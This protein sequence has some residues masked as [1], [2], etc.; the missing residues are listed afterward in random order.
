M[1]FFHFRLSPIF[2]VFFFVILTI[3]PDTPWGGQDMG[4]R[5]KKTEIQIYPVL[6]FD[7]KEWHIHPNGPKKVHIGPQVDRMYDQM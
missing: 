5:R 1:F 4:D 2:C 3:D 6:S 7:R